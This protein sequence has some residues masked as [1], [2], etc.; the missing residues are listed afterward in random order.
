MLIV[1]DVPGVV[2]KISKIVVSKG[3]GVAVADKKL[4]DHAVDELTLIAGQ[5]AIATLSKKDIASFYGFRG[6]S[7]FF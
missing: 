1:I 7:Y 5:K 6:E 2:P 3:V 4:I